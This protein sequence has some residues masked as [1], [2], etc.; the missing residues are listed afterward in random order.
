MWRPASPCARSPL[1]SKWSG[2]V[3]LAD[4]L[5]GTAAL[6]AVAGSTIW[7]ARQV[8]RAAL[9]AWRGPEAWLAEVVLGLV[10]V[11]IPAQALGAVGR[12]RPL[13]VLTTLVALSTAGGLV[14]R[15]LDRRPGPDPEPDRPPETPRPA[16]GG[17]ALA[18]SAAGTGLVVLQ[19]VTHTVDAMGRGMTQPDT[20]WYHGPFSARFLQRGSFSGLGDLGYESARYF[21]FNSELLH[22]LVAMPYDRD[23][24]SPVVNLLFAA[25]TLLAAWVIGSRRGVGPV[26]VLAAAMVLSLPVMAGVQPGQGSNDLPC[27]ALLLAAVALLLR[28]DLEP[29]PTGLAA[30]AAGLSIGFKL[31]STVP[32]LVLGL[33]VVVLALRRGRRTTALVWCA[34]AVGAAGFWFARNWAV[35]GNPLPWFGFRLGP[36]DF[37]Q[38]IDES[39]TSLSGQLTEW[40]LWR[41]VYLPGLREGFGWAW[42]LLIVLVASTIVLLLARR[43]SPMQRLCGVALVA[44]TVSYVLT[45]LTG[46]PGFVVNLR[47]AGPV[48][49]VA[50]A[51]LPVVVSRVARGPEAVA[52]ASGILIGSSLTTEGGAS[53]AAWPGGGV[54]PAIAITLLGLAAVGAMWAVVDR[55]D[56]SSRLVLSALVAFGVLAGWWAQ[57]HYLE[58]RYVD[59]DIALDAVNASFRGTSGST[60]AMFGTATYPMFG[61]DL[62]NRVRQVVRPPAPT[63]RA[64]CEATRR[65]LSDDFDYVVITKAAGFL[66]GTSV[67]EEW[68]SEDPAATEHARD[69]DGVAFRIEG[70][71]DP[72]ACR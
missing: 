20:L 65:L 42:P 32:L 33:G 31:T 60:V 61:L 1:A 24:L 56:T 27:A 50:A 70:S 45:P 34:A 30:A 15:R 43:S 54:L 21:P 68:I 10:A 26:A 62:S 51:L 6:V 71:L 13:W 3:G 63:E 28:S 5:L 9:P 72:S 59:A 25:V 48:L 22:A 64:A 52:A 57:R 12:L 14:A 38:T 55:R 2:G 47:Y 29:W 4:Y 37:E 18:L 49:L 67:P 44:G 39:G 66:V 40:T 41:E 17:A 46:G 36:V 19:W 69:E 16:I 58:R 35:I 23:F 7:A 8:R 11:L 53:V